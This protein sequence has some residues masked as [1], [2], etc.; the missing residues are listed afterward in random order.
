MGT[1]K[2]KIIFQWPGLTD[3]IVKSCEIKPVGFTDHF[4]VIVNGFIA[5]IKSRS[6]Y[7]H[8]N[9]SLLEDNFFKDV[10]CE[11]WKTFTV[12]KTCY[13]SLQQ[14]RDCGKIQIQQLCQQYTFTMSWDIAKSLEELKIEIVKLQNLV[15]STKNQRWVDVLKSKRRVMNDL[16]GIQ[17]P[18]ALIHSRF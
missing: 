14:W 5:N 12:R 15:E 9:V 2:K 10:F 11:F 16:L 6:A 7:W 17:A 4:M 1:E 3:F 18:G 13:S 8:F